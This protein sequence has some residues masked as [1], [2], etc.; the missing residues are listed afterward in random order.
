MRVALA[1]QGVSIGEIG[2]YLDS[3]FEIDNR[4]IHILLRHPVIGGDCPQIV[5]PCT[6][7]VRPF[8]SRSFDL[9]QC[10]L[11]SDHRRD[12]G[13]DVVLQLEEIIHP[14]VISLRPYM[15]V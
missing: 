3:F 8:F 4:R 13:N 5:V 6:E 12:A 14:A 11:G 9:S 10:D 1:K 2:I 7:I 15:A